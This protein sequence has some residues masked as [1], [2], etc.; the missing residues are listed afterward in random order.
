MKTIPAE[1]LTLSA[2]DLSRRLHSREI[3]AVEL[4][5]A[6]LERV[7][8]VNP[9]I[10]AIIALQKDRD[11]LFKEAKEAD[12]DLDSA[13]SDRNAKKPSWLRG[14]P[15]CVKDLED[16]QGLPTTF[17]G[18]PLFGKQFTEEMTTME[19]SYMFDN[20]WV[21][22]N[23][24]EDSAYVQRLREAG[25]PELGMGCHSYN[26]IHGTTLNPFDLSLSAGGSSG[27]AAAAIASYM[28]C[29]SDGS[30]MMGSLRNP[31]GWNN[32]YSLRP[33]SEWMEENVN[34]KIKDARKNGLELQYPISTIGPMARCPRD[35]AMFLDTILP[36]G[37]T[38][39]DAST[40]L[41]CDSKDL[42]EIVNGCKIGWLNDWGGSI[43]FEEGILDHCRAALNVFEVGGANIQDLNDASFSNDELWESWMIIRSHKIFNS[44]QERTCCNTNDL[45]KT[46]KARGVK[47][48]AIWECE[49]VE[50]QTKQQLK[51]AVSKVR[52]WS[53]CAYA[54]LER[55]DCL[56]LP[57]SQTYPFDAFNDWPRSIAG[58]N[59]D[60]YH[61]WMN[62]MVPVT[63]LGLPCITLPCGE[64]NT[65]MPVGLSICA[66]KG[67]DAFLLQLAVWHH[68]NLAFSVP[69]LLV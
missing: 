46:M 54:L 43:P 22:Q 21:F 57:S 2:I 61:R 20:G 11:K 26:T 63:L 53:S 23:A 40:V 47:S 68:N 42:D 62:V 34:D 30:D 31:A 60:T 19:N 5:K 12:F 13:A 28:L 59:M 25:A 38:Y 64:G 16:V 44:L 27:G 69:D 15:L 29:V 37:H 56:V 67:C 1:S 66:K 41:D 45:I 65:G 14:I 39:F 6:T 50:F 17:G 10:R 4:L 3:T 55:Y 32:L 8:E 49:Q 48:E 51:N 58:E 52:E 9:K 35:L 33:T 7:D 24:N 36:E 18:C